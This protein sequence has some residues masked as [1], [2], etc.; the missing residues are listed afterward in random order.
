M[1]A[2]LK[3]S[4]V[5]VAFVTLLTAIPA[6]ASGRSNGAI[7]EPVLSALSGSEVL[8]PNTDPVIDGVQA[9]VV[10]DIVSENARGALSLTGHEISVVESPT[11]GCA[12]P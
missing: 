12:R 5:L 6:G 4:T 1:R 2:F 9:N 7:S 11:T 8:I 10:G 3:H